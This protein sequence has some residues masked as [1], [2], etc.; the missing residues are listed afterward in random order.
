MKVGITDRAWERIARSVH[1]TE[2]REVGAG[3]RLPL[4]L[5]SGSPVWVRAGALATPPATDCDRCPD[6][7]PETWRATLAGF[8]ACGGAPD[9][10]GTLTLT[11]T[12]GCTWAGTLNGVAWTLAYVSGAWEL[13]DDTL[14]ARYTLT[15]ANWECVGPNELGRTDVTGC[16]SSPESLTLSAASPA[17]L[18]DGAYD[19]VF[20]EWDNDA[21]EF[22][23]SE[24]PN[25]CYAVDANGGELEEGTVYGGAVVWQYAEN[26]MVL[27]AVFGAA[28]STT[29]P[30]AYACRS[31]LAGLRA[32]ECVEYV[33]SGGLVTEDTFGGVWDATA[34]G[35]LGDDLVTTGDGL[36]YLVLVRKGDGGMGLKLVGETT[37][38]YAADIQ[39]CVD[40]RQRFAVPYCPPDTIDGDGVDSDGSGGGC[41]DLGDCDDHTFFV[42]VKCGDCDLTLD[43]CDLPPFTVPRSLCMAVIWDETKTP[44]DC[45]ECNTAAII[46]Y[47]LHAID[48]TDYGNPGHTGFFTGWFNPATA[49]TADC[50]N[51]YTGAGASNWVPGDSFDMG[52]RVSGT[53]TG[54]V[55]EPRF[56]GLPTGSV[57]TSTESAIVQGGGCAS[58]AAGDITLDPFLVDANVTINVPQVF[59][60]NTSCKTPTSLLTGYRIIVGPVP[61]GGCTAENMLALTYAGV[62][63]APACPDGAADEYTITLAGGTGDFAVL[64][65]SWTL[66]HT[67]GD[68]WV[69]TLGAATATLDASTGGI[70]FDAPGFTPLLGA[71]VVGPFECCGETTYTGVDGD[72]AT[73]DKPTIGTLAPVGDC[74]GC[75]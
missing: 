32:N 11:Y 30:T 38:W 66:T 43:A 51:L 44:T 55:F 71:E 54:T 31:K 70:I 59:T 75:P 23:D 39:V 40:G 67:T 72:P 20:V 52:M 41:A 9:P 74:A 49:T 65:G 21:A 25:T 64:N 16:G 8:A 7:A 48:C 56:A 46:T 1:F 47:G 18:R 53:G 2:R 24:E 22:I 29:S 63:D 17:T 27:V 15:G 36:T 42:D 62:C 69:G 60:P 57:C 58:V 28:T 73:G 50:R 35:W 3:G 12:T 68:T 4:G 61:A 6:G 26:G 10:N 33:V 13:T 14:G 45:D 34:G 5:G 37:T 19:A